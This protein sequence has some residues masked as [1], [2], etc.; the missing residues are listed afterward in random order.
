MTVLDL[1]TRSMR[2][3]GCINIGENPTAPEA[4]DAL[5]ALNAMVDAWATERLMCFTSARNIYNLAQNQQVYQIGPLGPDWIAPRPEYLDG[6]GLLLANSDPTQVIE[7]PLEV[8]RT[9]KEWARIHAKGIPSTIPTKLYYDRG[10]S[11]GV[12]N[13]G[14]GNVALWPI[15]TVVNQV[16]LYTPTIV[17]QFTGLTQTISLPPGYARTLPYNLAIEMAP[18]FDKEPSDVVVAIALASKDSL[19]RANLQLDK[20][21]TDLPRGERGGTWDYQ[22]GETR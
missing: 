22:L 9:D 19:K 21:R 6:A 3:L 8:L 1:I 7:I 15:P 13:L 11:T 14:S 20:L 12:G 2:L 18:E 5:L 4:Q 16:A 10:Y 17:S